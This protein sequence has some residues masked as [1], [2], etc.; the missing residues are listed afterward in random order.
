MVIQGQIGSDEEESTLVRTGT[1]KPMQ[2]GQGCS[3]RILL[4]V[5][6][7]I[8]LVME[9]GGSRSLATL[10]PPIQAGP[11][12][13]IFPSHTFLGFANI[14]L[15]VSSAGM[16]FPGGSDGKES[17][18]NAGDPGLIPGLGRSPGE[19]EWLPT[20]VFLLGE[21]YGQRCLEGYSPWG[22]KKSDTTKATNI[23]HNLISRL[24]T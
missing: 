21:F 2:E 10:G 6:G 17:A 15:N 9:G 11:L 7:H 12:S 1:K 23:W 4:C 20:P 22:H 5:G 24:A 19:R 18:C 16:G 8:I 14:Y 13:L 3:S